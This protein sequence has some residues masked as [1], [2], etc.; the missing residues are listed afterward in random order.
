VAIRIGALTDSA[1]ISR[2]IGATRRMLVASPDYLLRH[3]T[4]GS[5]A[6]LKS[7]CLILFQAGEQRGDWSFADGQQ[8]RAAKFARFWTNSAD[9]AIGHALDD[10]GIAAIFC[11]QAAKAIEDGRLVEVLGSFATPGVPIHALFTTR[12][13]LSAKVRAFL[14]LLGECS[15]AARVRGPSS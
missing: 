5:P 3:G 10:G 15:S 2:R 13:L 8:V 9:A 11:Y 4:P 1:L 12:R 14:D 6:E 7:H